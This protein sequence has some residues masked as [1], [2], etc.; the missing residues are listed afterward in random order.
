MMPDISGL[1]P[2]VP[3][4]GPEDTLP[5]SDADDTIPSP[6]PSGPH[7]ISWVEKVARKIGVELYPERLND[8]E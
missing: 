8:E 3:T 1:W 2:V 7:A 5:P 6:P 4:R